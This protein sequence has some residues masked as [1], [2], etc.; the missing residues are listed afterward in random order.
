MNIQDVALRAGVSTATVSRTFS[1]PDKVTE[2]TRQRVQRIAAE[3]GYIPNSSARV[4]RTRRSRTLGIVLPTLLNPV[5]SECLDGIALAAQERDYAIMPITTDYV[6]E[7][8]KMAVNRLI[9]ANVDGLA[10]VVSNPA[11]SPAL[12][13]L[14]ARKLPYVLIYNHHP[15]HPCITVDSESAVVEIVSRLVK[16]GHRSIAMLAG[17]LSASDRAQQRYRGYLLG[18]EKHDI[19]VPY[20]IEVPF[21]DAAIEKISDH[22]LKK[23]RP[24]ALVCSNDLLAIRGMRAAYECRLSVPADLSVVGFDGITLGL[25]LTPQLTTI[26]QPNMELGRQAIYTLAAAID[27]N[28]TLTGSDSRILKYSVRRGESADIAP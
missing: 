14:Q 22:L 15:G 1:S 27:E 10:L 25:D 23:N 2:E 21:M 26:V 24:S 17:Q 16:H 18:L 6:L 7:N 5:F 9:A 13:M 3:L 4:L 28:A 8:E 12:D 20:L 19:S 11:D